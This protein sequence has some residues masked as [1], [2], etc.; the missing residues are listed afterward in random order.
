MIVGRFVPTAFKLLDTVSMVRPAQVAQ[1]RNPAESR[2]SSEIDTDDEIAAVR[3]V[4]IH[5]AHES[6]KYAN[7]PLYIKSLS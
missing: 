7:L 1:G 3:Q 6:C 5:D 4:M 2:D